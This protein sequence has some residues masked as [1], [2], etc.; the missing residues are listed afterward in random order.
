VARKV[1]TPGW[2]RSATQAGIVAFVEWNTR[3]GSQY[4][5]RLDGTE[6]E[7]TSSVRSACTSS[8]RME[9]GP[10]PEVT[11][12]TRMLVPGLRTSADTRIVTSRTG[13]YARW[14][15]ATPAAT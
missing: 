14:L 1:I 11:V 8:T 5:Q 9:T 4:A 15:A 7:T 6:S 13:K 10:R 3:R 12:S 2:K